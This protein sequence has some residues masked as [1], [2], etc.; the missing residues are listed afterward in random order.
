MNDLLLDRFEKYFCHPGLGHDVLRRGDRCIA[1]RNVRYAI[2]YLL[3]GSAAASDDPELFDAE[4]ERHVKALQDHF[5]HR[6]SDGAVGPGTRRLIISNLLGRFDASIFKRFATTE[7]ARFPSVFMSYARQDKVKVDKLVQ[8]L[9]DHGVNVIVDTDS[10]IAGETIHDSIRRAVADAD[11]VVAVLSANSR[12]RDWPQVETAIAEQLESTLRE[13][14]LIYLRLDA[15]PLHAHDVGRIAIEC[16]Q[17]PLR[18]IG[19]E[20]LAALTHAPRM[21]RYDYDENELL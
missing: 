20:I 10:F 12:N 19:D 7:T 13:P 11:K 1:C 17:K 18:Q 8:W 9:R 6:V 3:G 2:D 21:T 14:I 16:D 4:L 5:R 15:T